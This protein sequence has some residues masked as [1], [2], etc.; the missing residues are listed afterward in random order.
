MCVLVCLACTHMAGCVGLYLICTWCGCWGSVLSLHHVCMNLPLAYPCTACICLVC[1]VCVGGPACGSVPGLHSVC[2]CTHM[3]I[4]L[5][6]TAHGC[7]GSS[8]TYTMCGGG[9]HVCL[10]L[11]CTVCVCRG[12]L[13]CTL[14]MWGGHLY[15]G[16]PTSQSVH[17]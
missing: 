5:A 11:G 2:V 17:V 8:L 15:V 9:V 10:S 1:T 4:C 16:L 13:A 12:C 3:H 14:C 7:G 6:C